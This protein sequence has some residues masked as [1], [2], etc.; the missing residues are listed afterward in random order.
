MCDRELQC[1]KPC[2]TCVL[3]T[4]SMIRTVT[5]DEYDAATRSNPELCPLYA[6]GD[7]RSGRELLAAAAS[8]AQH[9][10]AGMAATRVGRAELDSIAAAAERLYFL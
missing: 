7:H 9:T 2:E 6:L 5:P 3:Q 1:R 8:D 4:K 10:V